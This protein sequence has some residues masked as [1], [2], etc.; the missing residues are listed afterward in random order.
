MVISKKYARNDCICTRGQAI[1]FSK[2]STQG[3]FNLHAG[4]NSI[5]FKRDFNTR[6]M[7]AFAHGA[8]QLIFQ[9]FFT[10]GE[11]NLHTGAN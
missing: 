7:V 2:F 4:A 1:H 11:F 3:E 8:N 10:Q 5:K 9:N 6:E